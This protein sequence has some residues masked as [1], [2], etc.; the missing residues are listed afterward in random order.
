MGVCTHKKNCQLQSSLRT[1]S[2][3]GGSHEKSR[4]NS[5]RKETGVRGARKEREILLSSAP[6]GLATHSRVLSWLA[7]VTIS[8][9]LAS[10]S[11]A[12][13]VVQDLK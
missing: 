8:G 2:P 6:Y 7:S 11:I 10:R 13:R 4:E 9:E 3:F 5:T 1:S 12:I